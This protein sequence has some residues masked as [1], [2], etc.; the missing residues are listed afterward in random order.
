MK[1]TPL[2]SVLIPTYNRAGLTME[3]VR[4]VLSQSLQDFEII[5]ADNCSDDGSAEQLAEFCRGDARIRFLCNSTNLG[6]VGN[7]R[8]CLEAA[9]G[10]YIKWL[11]S[12]DLLDPECLQRCTD[13]LE[14]HPAAAFVF[15]AVK[16]F[17]EKKSA[18]RYRLGESGEY[19]AERF[20]SG[21]FANCCSLPVSPGCA[22][23]RREDTRI[24]PG[25][26]NRLQARHLETGAGIDLWMLLEPLEK[27]GRFCY[28]REPLSLFRDHRQSLTVA[29]NLFREY[30]TAKLAWLHRIGAAG[31]R[32]TL[33]GEVFWMELLAGRRLRS[34]R[35]IRADYDWH[36]PKARISR[37]RGLLSLLRKL[38]NW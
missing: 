18:E 2:V 11:W 23:L 24:V 9:S 29:N 6:P 35:R 5:V 20:Y 30:L 27:Y 22:L 1:K 10:R 36:Q 19:P 7:W 13:V 37:W 3:A 38:W 14:N 16:I 17:N 28:I 15:S 25:I 31:Y 8:V 26:E 32:S 12:D 33:L 21:L 4:S 34:S